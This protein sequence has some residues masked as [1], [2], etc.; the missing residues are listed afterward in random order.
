MNCSSLTYPERLV[1]G[2]EAERED[3][4]LGPEKP[5]LT[6]TLVMDLLELTQDGLGI[7][8]LASQVR[9]IAS[10]PSRGRRTR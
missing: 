8:K 10:Q 5:P 6:H 7:S 1:G 2:F 4:E 9:V 3:G